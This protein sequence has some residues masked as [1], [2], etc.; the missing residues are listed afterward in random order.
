MLHISFKD[1]TATSET[2]VMDRNCQS[3]FIYHC[4]LPESFLT[5]ILHQLFHCIHSLENLKLYGINL[6][7]FEPLLD[8]LLDDLVAHHEAQ[9]GV[10]QLWLQL[11]SGYNTST[12][13]FTTTN[14]S[15]E[16]VKKWNQRCKGIESIYCDIN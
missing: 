7:P 9:K 8:E 12:G 13:R 6:R 4:E 1:D 16:F 2:L 5:N 14:L 11:K 3:L 15:A 10:R